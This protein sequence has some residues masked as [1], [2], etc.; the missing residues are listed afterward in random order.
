MLGLARERAPKLDVSWRGRDRGKDQQRWCCQRGI[1]LLVGR[2]A[3]H[4][5]GRFALNPVASADTAYAV[6]LIPVEITGI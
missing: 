4:A 2:I 3:G 6:R 5:A 1:Y